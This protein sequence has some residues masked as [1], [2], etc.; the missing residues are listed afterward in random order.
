METVS[1][2]SCGWGWC[3]DNTDD[4][5]VDEWEGCGACGRIDVGI[6]CGDWGVDV[7]CDE[8]CGC[9]TGGIG[10]GADN[11][12]GGFDVISCTGAGVG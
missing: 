10:G 11:V 12:D 9:C 5:G 7:S 4:G 8:D 2:V 6:S 3:C 1:R